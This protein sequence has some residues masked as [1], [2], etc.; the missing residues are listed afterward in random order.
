MMYAMSAVAMV[1]VLGCEYV[2]PVKVA[3]TEPPAAHV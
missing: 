3:N 2:A 1:L